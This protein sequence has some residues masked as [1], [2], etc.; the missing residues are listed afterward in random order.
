MHVVIIGNGIAGINVASG[1]TSAAVAA[2]TAAGPV[3]VE[4]FAAEA[5]QLYSRVRL[6]EVLSGASAP[7]AIAF[8]KP[9]W[10]EK[11]NIAVHTGNAVTAIDPAA[12]KITLA[13]GRQIAYDCLVLATGA[14][15]NHPPLPGA[16]LRGV[17]TLRTMDDVAAIRNHLAARSGSASVIGGGLL[18]LEAARALKDGGVKAVRVFEIAPRLLPRQLDE[19]GAALL[20]TRFASMGIEVLCDVQTDGFVAD[21][22]D[23]A[24]SGS[25]RLKDGRTFPSDLTILS[26][27]VH[28]NT[29]LAKAAGLTVNRGI[30][31][32]NRLRTSDPSIYAVGDCAEFEGIVWGIIPAA[33]EQAPV[34]A[35]N[36]LHD[37]GLLDASS[38]PVYAQTVPKT[39]LKIGEIEL[40]SLGKAVLTAEETGSGSFTVL[41]RVWADESRYEKFV[42]APAVA[43]SGS[44]S[45]P[46]GFTLAGAILYGSKKHQSAVQKMM[47]AAVSLAEVEAMLKDE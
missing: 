14:S 31:V 11:K 32:D 17:F 41:S 36:I 47:G 13:D 35:K 19:T 4:V 42:L 10:Y 24:L 22:G 28:S 26:M 12:K 38:T 23:P 34:A 2:G 15:A 27:G 25:V 5:H 33:L 9:E 46:C 3:S 39:A 30:V 1:L 18:G 7:E 6:P 43:D 29:A 40:M 8:Y 44:V 16:D 45:L 37:N 21:S 20:Q